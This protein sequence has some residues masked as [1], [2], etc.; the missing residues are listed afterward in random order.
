MCKALCSE[1]CRAHAF[2]LVCLGSRDLLKRGARSRTHAERGRKAIE[3]RAKLGAFA[4]RACREPPPPK[5]PLAYAQAKTRAQAMLPASQIQLHDQLLNSRPL[6]LL[7]KAVSRH[8]YSTLGHT[9]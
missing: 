7:S 1:S 4:Q 8:T 9:R 6:A 3:V 2:S 5:Q